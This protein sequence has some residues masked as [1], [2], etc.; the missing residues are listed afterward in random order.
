MRIAARLITKKGSDDT[1]RYDGET[2]YLFSPNGE[3]EKDKLYAFVM[4]YIDIYRRPDRM[5]MGYIKFVSED[6]IPEM[7]PSNASDNNNVMYARVKKEN[8]DNTYDIIGWNEYDNRYSF[9]GYL[10]VQK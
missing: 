5:M 7:L 2:M 8:Q 9:I 1:D 3:L 4:V 6:D 10:E